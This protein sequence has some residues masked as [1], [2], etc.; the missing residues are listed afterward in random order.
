MKKLFSLLLMLAMLT[1]IALPAF[2]EGA[3]V[4]FQVN[5]N[6]TVPAF[7]AET[8]KDE[9]YDE[10]TK[11]FIGY[12]PEWTYYPWYQYCY[13]EI[14]KDGATETV[15]LPSLPYLIDNTGKLG[16]GVMDSQTSDNPWQVGGTYDATYYAFDHETGETVCEWNLKVTLAE[17]SAKIEISKITMDE[18]AFSERWGEGDEPYRYYAWEQ[19]GRADVKIDG[20]LYENI[21]M[22]QLQGMLSEKFGNAYYGW[23]ELDEGFDQ[24]YNPWKAGD[25]YQVR[26]QIYGDKEYLLDSP[27]TVEVYETKIASVSAKP[28][29]YYAY[30]GGA[31]VEFVVTYKDNTTG[32]CEDLDWSF[33]GEYPEEPGTYTIT[34][35]V[36]DTFDVPVQVTVLPTPT[37]GKLGETVEWKYDATTETLTVFGTGDTYY[38]N[39]TIGSNSDEFNDWNNEWVELVSYLKPRHLVV[40]E[41]VTGLAPGM[42]V[43]AFAAEDVQLPNSLK[44]MPFALVGVN[45]PSADVDL[46]L[47]ITTKGVTTLVVP[48]NI[49][50]WKNPTFYD[51]W[52][53]TDIY[54]PAG[55]T[56]INIDN[57]IHTTWLR[58]ERMELPALQTKIHF[59]GTKAQWDAI[60][61][62]PGGGD[63]EESPFFTGLSVEEAK[64]IL[65]TFTITYEDPALS[66]QEED[67][68]V[69]NGVASVPDSVVE[70]VT[71]KDT[72]I[73]VSNTAEK[74]DS[75]ELKPETVDK[76]ADAKTNVEI[77]LP[78]MKVSFD[79]TAISSVSEQAGQ[80]PVTLLAKK[81]AETTLNAPQK[82]T[83][84]KTKI[85]ECLSLEV[86][87]GQTKISGFGG[88]KVTVSVP[89]ALPAGK[90]GEDFA[91]IYLEDKGMITVMPTTY[92]AGYIRFFTT[93]FSTYAI[94][95][96]ATLPNTNP[97]TGDN[98]M[99][100]LP[101]ALLTVSLL[102]LAVCVTKR[103]A[104]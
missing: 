24:Q 4:D 54:L 3:Q 72:V 26:L 86:N 78:E 20:K 60:T 15:Q 96:T 61:F 34:F 70:I 95:E 59:A 58:Q 28:M 50:E 101:V 43:Y 83:L 45:G 16:G 51:C 27:V 14:T 1:A 38:V 42:F 71:G 63:P 99:L 104:F 68:T 76:L 97:K 56:T 55:I 74:A 10:E 100:I 9:V 90:T 79:K 98:A 66:Y 80:S 5:L 41:G 91:V 65:K 49:K 46:G 13:V 23:R 6:V 8:Y 22:E 87:A 29:T 25:S 85:Y 37:S 7:G 19:K 12:G 102:G 81:V 17:P 77:K 32:P 57:L 94:V 18:L 33:Q 103:R 88:G 84:E 11:D 31:A 35:K 21:T 93:H 47:D 92:E 69:D 73:D 48:K 62:L 53:V 52:G 39:E 75:V 44:T 40:E 36:A 2:A 82:E 67:I 30:Q 89:F 64:E